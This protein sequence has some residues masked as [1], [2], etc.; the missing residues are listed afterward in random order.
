MS[1]IVD[2]TKYWQIKVLNF[3]I[4]KPNDGYKTTIQKYN[5]HTIKENLLLL[6]KLLEIQGAKSANI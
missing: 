4:D 3:A 1:L 6:K 2:Q 5:Q